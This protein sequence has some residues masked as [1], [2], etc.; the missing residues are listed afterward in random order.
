MRNI[1]VLILISLSLITFSQELNVGLDFGSNFIKENPLA[2]SA[3]VEYRPSKS[4]MSLNTGITVITASS[5]TIMSFPLFIKAIIGNEFRISPLFGGFI[6]TN[7]NYG[8]YAG[9]EIEY[10]LVSHSAIFV[11][12]EYTKEFYKND[13]PRG[14]VI[15]KDSSIW[16]RIGFKKKLLK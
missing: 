16:V 9:L 8:W 10:Y 14:Y 3:S 4:I 15:N 13:T 11:Q 12:G 6:R 2:I 7:E 1:L 5:N